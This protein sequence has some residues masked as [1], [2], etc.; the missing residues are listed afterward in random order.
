[1]TNGKE[2]SAEGDAF[3]AIASE[4][5]LIDIDSMLG[6]PLLR[7]G[8][9]ASAEVESQGAFRFVAFDRFPQEEALA[10]AT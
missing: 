3:D 6:M 2:N 4:A 7:G 9:T 10:P 5:L 8:G 1:M